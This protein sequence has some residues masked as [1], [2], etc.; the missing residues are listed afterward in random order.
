VAELDRMIGGPDRVQDAPLSRGEVIGAP[1][2]AADPLRV[3][4]VNYS[5]EADFEVPAGQWQLSPGGGLP[6]PGDQCLVAFDDDD[7]AWVLAW[8]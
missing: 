1:A 7:D 6:G 4:L 2:S 5:R 3:V 8:H